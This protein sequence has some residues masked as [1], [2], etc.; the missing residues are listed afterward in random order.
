MKVGIIDYEGG[1]LASVARAVEHLGFQPTITSDA[2][3]LRN[4][5]KVIFP[6]VGAAGAAMGALENANLLDCVRRQ[7]TEEEVPC[8]GICIGIQMLFDHSEEDDQDTL[9]ILPGQVK[10]FDSNLGV[11]VPHIGWNEVSFSENLPEFLL[12]GVED[13]AHFY[14]VNSYYVEPKE[15]SVTVGRTTYGGMTFTSMVRARNWTATQFHLEK[16][17]PAGL[18]LL[19]NFL[20]G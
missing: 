5:D 10:R 1:N 19:K 11:K 18:R 14:F 9:G 17:G 2:S 7:L 13:G 15:E 4:S 12:S 20:E 6:G 16:S 3:V 8:L